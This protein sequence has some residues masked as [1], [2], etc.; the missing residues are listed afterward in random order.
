MIKLILVSIISFPI[1]YFVSL[2]SV[3]SKTYVVSILYDWFLKP[4]LNLEIGFWPLSGLILLISYTTTVTPLLTPIADEF[5][6]ENWKKTQLLYFLS[7]PWVA[8]LIGWLIKSKFF[9]F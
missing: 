2:Y 3:F 8:L 4:Y 9:F 1:A 7:Y 6:T 5:K